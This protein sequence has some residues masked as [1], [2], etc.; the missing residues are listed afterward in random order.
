M[1]RG[2][3]TFRACVTATAART[4]PRHLAGTASAPIRRAMFRGVEHLVVPVVALIEGVIEPENS[5]GPELV[6]AEDL[7]IAPQGWNGRPVVGPHPADGNGSAS[8]STPTRL[9]TL[10]FG[11]LFE[12]HVGDTPHGP[13]LLVE[14]WLNEA[15]A[16]A[17]G[18][19]EASVIE[20]LLAEPPQMVEVSV[21][22]FVTLIA[23]PGTWNGQKYVGRWS[24]IVPDH[25]AML[26]PGVPGACS[27]AA[28]CGAPRTARAVRHLA[29]PTAAQI[30]TWRGHLA[31]LDSADLTA[32]AG[33]DHPFTYC[34]EVVV[35]AME[36]AGHGPDDPEAFCGWWKSEHAARAAQ[37]ESRMKPKFKL[38]D[39]IRRMVGKGSGGGLP[40]TRLDY[41][42]AQESLSDQDLRER[43]DA[44]L[45]ATVPGYLWIEVVFPDET[46][47]IYSAA[48]GELLTLNQQFFTVAGDGVVSLNG[49]AIEVEQIVRYEPVTAAAAPAAT[50]PA[51]PA[52]PTAAPATAAAVPAP[53]HAA[54]CACHECRT[55]AAAAAPASSSTPPAAAGTVSGGAPAPP[56]PSSTPT[57][58]AGEHA[59]KERTKKLID[60]SAG[61]FTAA[62]AVWLDAVPDDRIEL[63]AD[64]GRPA[65][66][67]TP[68]STGT[69]ST[70]PAGTPS[71]PPATST[72]PSTS[73][74]PAT[75]ETTAPPAAAAAPAAA[76][77]TPIAAK[78]KSKTEWLAEAPPEVRAMVAR[79]DADDAA[80][81][82]ALLAT[83]KGKTGGAYTDPELDAMPVQDLARIAK[84]VDAKAAA[85]IAATDYSGA[86]VARAATGTGTEEAI[87]PTPDLHERVRAAAGKPAKA[88]APA[89]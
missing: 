75:S 74:P 78:A 32:A 19:D 21:G 47:V 24:A 26:P 63:L 87:P 17:C 52:S 34:M 60:E 9:E 45:R 46:S 85:E 80:R 12:G 31:G 15:Q 55:R 56:A 69:P 68:P 44:A 36:D 5:D 30:E 84:L 28:G 18:A 89:A 62:D 82:T 22:V 58:A 16:R 4:Q 20:R 33:G 71:T 37:K 11:T 57:A 83:L 73:T 76:E 67:P 25:L 49:N 70:P 81:K 43:L 42:L 38:T 39:V 23:A 8:A 40:I 61:K 66:S 48:P 6:L 72:P 35:P 29:S 54:P 41:R 7:A 88:A 51:A 79:H 2:G 50:P 77:A 10:A 27:V 53:T 64:K 65:G 1:R 86:V 59:M 3:T 13:A 14:A